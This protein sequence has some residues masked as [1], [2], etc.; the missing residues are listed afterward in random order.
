LA[1]ASGH[2]SNFRVRV[3]TVHETAAR[4]A[5]FARIMKEP[6]QLPARL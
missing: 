5:H 4:E 1:P 3:T 2:D 6:A